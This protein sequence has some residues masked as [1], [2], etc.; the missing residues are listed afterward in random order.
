MAVGAWTLLSTLDSEQET[1]PSAAP[2]GG[3]PGWGA[4]CFI[5][6]KSSGTTAFPLNSGVLT[7]ILPT[8]QSQKAS[9]E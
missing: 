3:E 9:A 2:L 4:G 6:W 1:K 5:T 7:R 8:P